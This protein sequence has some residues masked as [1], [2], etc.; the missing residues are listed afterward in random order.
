[1][2][3]LDRDDS[4]FDGNEAVRRSTADVVGQTPG[5]GP[6]VTA[7]KPLDGLSVLIVEDEV[8]INLD[9]AMTVESFGAREVVP[10]HS[11]EEAWAA[12]KDGSFDLAVLDLGLPDGD[13]MPLAEK[14]RGDG[15]EIV[16]YSGDD[17]RKDILDGFPRAGYVMKPAAEKAWSVVFAEV[18]GGSA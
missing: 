2:S 12:L 15:V 16:F 18:V 17:D 4:G 1:M 9:L 5:K 13:A 3:S 14:L 6:R 11:L 7:H 8:I 10:A